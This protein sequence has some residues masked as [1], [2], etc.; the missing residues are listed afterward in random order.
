M[1]EVMQ[2]KCLAQVLA[3]PTCPIRAS[4]VVLVVKNPPAKAGH[5]RD[6]GLIPG[7]G[8]SP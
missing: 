4:H 2:V 5:L 7:S 3:P 6:V 8:G 1:R